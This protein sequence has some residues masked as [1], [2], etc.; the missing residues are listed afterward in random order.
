MTHPCIRLWLARVTLAAT[1]IAPSSL[2]AQ[3]GADVEAIRKE[4]ETLRREIGDLRRQLDELRQSQQRSPVAERSIGP[5]KVSV[6]NAPALGKSGAP[7]TIVEF[8]DYQCPYCQRYSAQTFPELKR[9]YIDTGKVRYVLRDFPLDTI[10]P[11]ARKAGEAAHCAG[12]QGKYWEMHDALFRNIRMLKSEHLKERAKVLGLDEAAF[13]ACLDQ[14]SHAARVAANHEAG[15]ALG[16]S[17]TPSFFIG[18]TSPDGTMEA[19]L[20]RGAQPTANF[21]K[22]I[23]ALLDAKSGS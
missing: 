12:D 4:V 9:D 20:L 15:R 13:A 2:L 17:A 16:I 19:T 5:A 22:A 23:D 6:G 7:V 10:H 1:L 18:R 21:R 3:P 8:S 11:D 14:G